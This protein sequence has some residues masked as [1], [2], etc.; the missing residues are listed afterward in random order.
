MIPI[1]ARLCTQSTTGRA[2]ATPVI[3]VLRNGESR[4]PKHEWIAHL[5]AGLAADAAQR[6]MAMYVHIPFCQALCTFCGCNVRIARNHSLATPY[7]PR[8][9]R[10][11]ALYR[12][13][14]GR[15]EFQL[16]ALHLGGGTPTFLPAAEL[17]RLLDGLLQ[18]HGVPASGDR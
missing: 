18:R 6:G 16:G 9:L 17:D 15:S 13:R 4:P 7:V 2:R 8:L 14:L 1:R 10:E 5:D 3:R 11:L 12:E